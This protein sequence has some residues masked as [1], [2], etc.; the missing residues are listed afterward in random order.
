MKLATNR[1]INVNVF[2]LAR[3]IST[4]LIQL[5]VKLI[6]IEVKFRVIRGNSF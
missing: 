5:K 3:E 4:D 2:K 1:G 6:G